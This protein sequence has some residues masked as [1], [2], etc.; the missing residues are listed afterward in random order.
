MLCYL[1]TKKCF[2]SQDHLCPQ[3]TL[4]HK[5]NTSS[6]SE[7]VSNA[8]FT[9]VNETEAIQELVDEI[10]ELQA[11]LNHLNELNVSCFYYFIKVFPLKSTNYFYYY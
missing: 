2:A 6:W 4:P 5:R 10:T 7:S 8:N 9:N 1:Q 3:I 11:I